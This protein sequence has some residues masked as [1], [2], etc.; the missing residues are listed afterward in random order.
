VRVARTAH[1][2]LTESQALASC[3]EQ[4]LAISLVLQVLAISFYY[5]GQVPS[6]SL[7]TVRVRLELGFWH[8]REGGAGSRAAVTQRSWSINCVGDTKAVL[9]T[10]AKGLRD[11]GEIEVNE[12]YEP[13]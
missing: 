11:A 5:W 10:Y 12:L 9:S 4:V 8:C 3:Y 13:D 2:L 6:A 1:R 7:P